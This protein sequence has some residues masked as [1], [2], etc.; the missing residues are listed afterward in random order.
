[1]LHAANRIAVLESG[2]LAWIGTGAEA[3]RNTAIVDAYLGLG[4]G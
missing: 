4:E 2:R 1:V 3:A